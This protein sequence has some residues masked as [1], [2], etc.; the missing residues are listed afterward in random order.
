MEVLIGFVVIVIAAVGFNRWRRKVRWDMLMTKYGD[1]DVVAAIMRRAVWQGMS[2]EQLLDSRG[3]PLAIDEQVYKTKTKHVFKYD[4]DG[5]NRF[6]TRVTLE[7]GTVVG[8][9]QR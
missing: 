1:A 6:A 9:N 5:R 8:W 3:R 2:R 7:N 4:Q